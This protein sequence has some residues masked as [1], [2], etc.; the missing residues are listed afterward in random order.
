M[1]TQESR[2]VTSPMAAQTTTPVAA[3]AAAEAT[4]PG[5]EDWETATSRPNN[6]YL[7]ELSS[8]DSK[9]GNY[10]Q[11]I[12]VKHAD[13]FRLKPLT[14]TEGPLKGRHVL[15]LEPSTEH[16]PF[17]ELPAEIR[18]MI[19]NECFKDSRSM[20]IKL[21][22]TKKNG[23]RA[24]SCRRLLDTPARFDQTTKTWVNKP[25]SALGLLAVNKQIKDEAV[26]TLYSNV[27]DF[28]DFRTCQIFL[29]SIGTMLSLLRD[30]AFQRGSYQKSKARTLFFK[31]REAKGLRSLTFHFRDVSGEAR[32]SSVSTATFAADCKTM[33]TSFHKSRKA[34][35]GL[36][37][38]LELVRLIPECKFCWLKSIGI[39]SLAASE[40]TCNCEDFKTECE[41]SQKDFRDLI[42]K[43][44]G[45]EG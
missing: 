38:V 26:S 37:G 4:H 8:Y 33:M 11:D 17:L 5:F 23:L 43:S 41:E 31:L 27:F 36:P 13:A 20:K 40:K 21:F 18:Q 12:T 39:S 42:A 15:L 19:Y 16:F 45:V 24:I 9:S 29:E 7:S 6:A 1:P 28:P 14:I 34:Q 25:A 2:D 44:V 22:P 35:D 30:V 10:V 32:K 3:A